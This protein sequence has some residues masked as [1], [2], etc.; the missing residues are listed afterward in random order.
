MLVSLDLTV[1]F[2]HLTLLDELNFSHR[3]TTEIVIGF[4]N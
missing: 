1:G 3:P 4:L 2:A